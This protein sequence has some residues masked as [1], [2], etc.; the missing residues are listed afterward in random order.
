M[1]TIED[2]FQPHTASAAGFSNYPPGDVAFVTNGFRD[3]GVLGFVQPR[4]S[5][6]VFDFLGIVLSAFCEATVQIPPFI[7]RG[8]GGSGLIVLEPRKPMTAGELG[9]IAACINTSL[10]WRFNWYRQATVDRVRR[11]GVPTPTK[12]PVAFSVKTLLP[13]GSK[14]TRY[15]TWQPRFKPFP[16]DAMF[17]LAAGDYHN[18]SEL[19]PGPIPLVSCGHTDNGI[20]GFVTV[21]EQHIYRNLLTIAFNGM[22][23]LTT[24]YHPY[25]FA[26]KDDVA[27][28][29][30]RKEWRIATLVF[31][32]VMMAR[33]RWRY[34]YYRK[35]FMEKL[36]RQSVLLPAKAGEVD[37]DTIEII[38][39]STAYWASLKERLA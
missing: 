20:A 8:N 23:T 3:N 35:C 17:E 38:M 4:S 9:Y 39:G 12:R 26:T 1:P 25:D 10:K 16:L 29:V 31:I 33:E 5:D 7:A 28:C 30:P 2:I 27:I 18:A 6:E 22:N 19:P 11:L 13:A 21:P 34:S 15:A 37:E 32:Q 24:K 36:K 14:T